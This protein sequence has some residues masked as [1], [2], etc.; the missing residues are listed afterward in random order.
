M[1][2]KYWPAKNYVLPSEVKKESVIVV[3]IIRCYKP[4][5]LIFQL[6]VSRN[7]INCK[8]YCPAQLLRNFVPV[9]RQSH[10]LPLISGRG[11]KDFITLILLTST[12]WQ[13]PTNASKWRVGFNSAFKRVKVLNLQS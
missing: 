12:I 4:H 7:F 6:K 5:H 10:S 2:N 9:C 8:T 13:A 11:S 3:I 1:I